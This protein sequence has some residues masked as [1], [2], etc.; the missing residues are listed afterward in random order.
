[1]NA[2]DI[3]RKIVAEHQCHAV[4][5]REGSEYDAKPY[6]TGNHRGW[7]LIDGFSASAIVQV[8]D[9]LNAENKVKFSGLDIAKMAKVAFKLCR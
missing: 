2:I 7:L 9:A 4:R 3:C 8:Y 6:G 5:H 1:M